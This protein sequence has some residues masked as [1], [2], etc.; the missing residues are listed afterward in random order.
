MRQGF[1]SGR[2]VLAGVKPVVPW[3]VEGDKTRTLP[4]ASV[5]Q[6]E[7]YRL[8]GAKRNVGQRP[9]GDSQKSGIVYV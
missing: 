1:G 9:C 7:K 8:K 2:P 5:T 3:H 6:R 4:R